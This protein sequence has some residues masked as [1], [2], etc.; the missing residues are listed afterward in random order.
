LPPTRLFVGRGRERD[1]FLSGSFAP[2]FMQPSLKP[3]GGQHH[4]EPP[5]SGKPFVRGMHA[6]ADEQRRSRRQPR[7]NAVSSQDRLD[8]SHG[9]V[10][11]DI[12]RGLQISTE[13]LN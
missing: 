13:T 9:D 2:R 1:A 5:V 4:V 12:L 6:F 10:L 11:R 7:D 3:V 8:A